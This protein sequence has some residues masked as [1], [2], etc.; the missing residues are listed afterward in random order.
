MQSLPAKELYDFR[1]NDTCDAVGQKNHDDHEQ[2]ADN[3]EVVLGPTADIRLDHGGTTLP[4]IAP[5]SVPTPPVITVITALPEVAKNRSSGDAKPR[6]IDTRFESDAIVAVV[7]KQLAGRM[8]PGGIPE[9]EFAAH[10]L[11]HSDQ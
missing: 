10:S 11:S 1:T 4:V 7:R 2:D 9:T 8:R 6:N 5:T 3:D